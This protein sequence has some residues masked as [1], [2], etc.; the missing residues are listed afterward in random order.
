[1]KMQEI[2]KIAKNWNVDT[3]I[4]RSKAEV[5]RDIQIREGFSPCYGTKENCA[6][7]KC[8]WRDDCLRS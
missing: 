4:G 3:R 5:I 7:N 1:M 6:E 2:K 8:L